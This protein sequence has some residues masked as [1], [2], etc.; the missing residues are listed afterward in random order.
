MKQMIELKATEL[1][2]IIG[3]ESMNLLEEKVG[4]SK[5]REYRELYE[6]A[7]KLEI[8]TEFP[9]QLD[10]ELNA[11]CNL[12]C[13]MCPLSVETNEQKGPETWFKF[14]KFK[15]IIDDGVPRGL[16]ALKLNYLNEPLIRE[17]LF[18]F[19]TYAKKA[20]VCDVYLSTNGV[21]LT[22][23]VGRKL[24]EAGLDRIQISIDAFAKA[25]YDEI[26]PGSDLE[27]VI[28]NTETLIRL[29]EEYQTKFPLIRV[30]FV[31]TELNETELENFIDYWYEKVDMIGIQ[32]M[33]KPEISARDLHSKTTKKK[34]EIGFRCSFPY[35][36]MTI[37]C[38][39]D[40]LPCCT[41]YAEKMKMGNI[42]T[43]SIY[44]VWNSKAM[45][46]LRALHKAGN[47]YE[48]E[49][50]KACADNSVF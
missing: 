4:S 22:E 34:S 35:K 13:P 17:D 28:K 48:N 43:D 41:F 36:L 1:T 33:I 39:G 31:R 40:I 21:L 46:G 9:I 45:K 49:V 14:D 16:K 7:S 8:E 29:K 6:Q 18:E 5:W 44:D 32:E 3:R 30:N 2:G 23:A 26:R 42:A 27:K 38:E 12:R 20:G 25:T 10:I 37:N 50:C 47:Y 24:I 15:A 11:S 19:I